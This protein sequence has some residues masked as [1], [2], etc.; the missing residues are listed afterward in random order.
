MN[1]RTHTHTL[2]VFPSITPFIFS[3]PSGTGTENQV[4]TRRPLGSPC[5]LNNFMVEATVSS[6]ANKAKALFGLSSPVYTHCSVSKAVL[7]RDRRSEQ[8]FC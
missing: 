3:Y 5:G 6:Q 4:F 2:K 1:M 7:I 8:M